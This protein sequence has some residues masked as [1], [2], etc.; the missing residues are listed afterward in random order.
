MPRAEIGPLARVYE[1]Q[2]PHRLV[3]VGERLS[4]AHDHDVG[5]FAEFSREKILGDDFVGRKR[6]D[7]AARAAGAERAAHRAAHLGGNALGEAACGGNEN[8]LDAVAVVKADEQF[9]RSVFGARRVEN[10]GV[11][12]RKFRFQGFAEILGQCRGA[13]P[14]VDVIAVKRLKNLVGAKRPQAAFLENRLPFVGQYAP[15]FRHSQSIIP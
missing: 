2:S 14:V 9:R 13:V 1:F 8:R 15:C 7:H 10:F 5:Y 12:E 6:A 4:H 3:V 11:R